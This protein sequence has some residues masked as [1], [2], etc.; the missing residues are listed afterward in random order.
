MKGLEELTCFLISQ[1]TKLLYGRG[2]YCPIVYP[3]FINS[4]IKG[5][6]IS[7]ILC[8]SDI[9]VVTVRIKLRCTISC[10]AQFSVYVNGAFPAVISVHHGYPCVCSYVIIVIKASSGITVVAIIARK[11]LSG[12]V[13]FCRTTSISLNDSYTI[14]TLI[15]ILR[16]LH[17][18]LTCMTYSKVKTTKFYNCLDCNI[19]WVKRPII[20]N[21]HVIINAI[22]KI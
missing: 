11:L 4:S 17:K 21:H 13:E 22:K 18:N 14:R 9:N 20:W 19:C 7:W 3:D 8:F 1:V 2:A 6:G 5:I 15:L 10:A 16:S 12:R